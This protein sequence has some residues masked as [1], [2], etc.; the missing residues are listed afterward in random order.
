MREGQTFQLLLTADRDRLQEAVASDS[1]VPRRVYVFCIDRDGTSTV[2][3][4]PDGQGD[5]ENRFPFT[6]A[7]A[8]PPSIIPLPTTFGISK[9]FGIDTFFLLASEEPL[10]S[11]EVLTFTGI[12][13][14]R[15][16]RGR[17]DPLGRL[18]ARTFESRRGAPPAV[19]M[20]WSLER[21]V[22]RSISKGEPSATSGR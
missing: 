14:Q 18:I 3:F 17:L 20:N 13:T 15:E 22:L 11:P 6:S 9:P 7:G 12:G 2:L 1:L 16:T 19:P 4:P 8:D 10:A 5:V 21:L